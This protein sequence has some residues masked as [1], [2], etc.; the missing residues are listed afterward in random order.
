MTMR[1]RSWGIALL[2]GGFW[3][4]CSTP[5]PSGETTDGSVASETSNDAPAWVDGKDERCFSEAYAP[6]DDCEACQNENCCN[7]YFTCYDDKSCYWADYT[8]DQ[9][10]D[11][12]AE[13]GTSDAWPDGG[14]DCWKLFLDMSGDA[15]QSLNT[16]IATHC[17]DRCHL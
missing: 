7:E 6:G 16:C 13:A 15:G 5:N 4:G 14:V 9:C 3:L 2:C 1:T 17:P 8:F 12:Q 10:V 11:E